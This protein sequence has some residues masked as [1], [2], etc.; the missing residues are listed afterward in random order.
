MKGGHFSLL[1][2]NFS[3][4]TKKVY[5]Y[6]YD[7]IVNNRIKPGSALSEVEIAKT[8]QSSRSPVREALM[9][10]ENEGLVWRY[11]GRGCFV[12]EIT[13]RDIAEIFELRILLETTALRRSCQ[14]I[15]PGALAYVEQKLLSLEGNISPAAY[16]EAD[17]L[18]HEL[19]WENC[20]NAR[21][22]SF[23]RTLS[24][25]IEW[26]RRLAGARPERF[27]RS[28][29]EHLELVAAIKVQD[30]DTACALLQKHIENVRANTEMV[31]IRLSTGS[32]KTTY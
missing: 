20:G 12:R 3:A 16:Y 19:I 32:G 29:Q 18:F 21:L 23:L 22:V 7:E 6:L 24:G 10:L 30:V 31:Y 15:D 8:L 5:E 1:S 14:Y 2:N 25:Q 13:M 27:A 26:I 11:P 28:R 4:A 9:V 17:R